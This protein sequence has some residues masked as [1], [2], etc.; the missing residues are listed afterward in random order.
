M[1]AERAG[2]HERYACGVPLVYAERAGRHERY[3]FG[4][5]LVYAER[6]GR[7][8]RYAYGVPLVY[9]GRGGVM[10]EPLTRLPQLHFRLPPEAARLLRAR[11]RVRDYLRTLCTDHD[12][13]DDVV[14]CVEEACTNAIRHSGTDAPVDVSLAFSD[15]ELTVQV[16]D[17]GKG[18]DV[19]AFDP[20]ATPDLMADGGR[21]LFLIAALMDQ[22]ELHVDGGLRL[23]MAKRGLNGRC[24]VPT[25]DLLHDMGAR[26]DQ[27]R[28]RALL[29]DIDEAFF[30]VDWEYRCVHANEAAGRLAG[31]PAAEL[32]GLTPFDVWPELRH[33]HVEQG[34][35]EAMELG[36]GSV[37]EWLSPRGRW[38]ELRLYPTPSGVAVYVRDIGERKRA[39]LAGQELL[40]ELR[41]SEER[42]RAT[43]EQAAVGMM[44]LALDGRYERVQRSP[45][46]DARLR[47]RRAGAA[48]L[49]PGDPPRRRDAPAARHRCAGRRHHSPRSRSRSASCGATA[50]CCGPRSRSRWWATTPVSRT[51]SW[52]WCRTSRRSAERRTRPGATSCWQ[53]GPATSCCSCASR[54]AASW[55]PTPPPRRPTATHARS[56]A[57]SPSSI[58]AATASRWCSGRCSRRRAAACC[59]RRST[60]A[61]TAPRSPSR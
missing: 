36:R 30:A 3:A 33:T 43:F 5:P 49:P 16:V 7:H 32:L 4:V 23:H 34:L 17:R 60:G 42:F 12:V 59:S 57:S 8:E 35:R 25:L 41:R 55:R 9:A 58:C 20:R 19:A 27:T 22:L 48:H 53:S 2:R 15:G 14:L 47:P 18:F 38:A 29:E 44:H 52:A 51:T 10:S 61:P 54:T 28:L 13:V 6:A 31:K 26:A 45:V 21:G 40:T 50:R 37:L 46:R 1:Y 56:C 39:E 11:E 24:A